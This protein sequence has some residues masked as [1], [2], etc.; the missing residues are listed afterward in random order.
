MGSQSNSTGVP[1]KDIIKTLLAVIY[2]EQW[3]PIPRKKNPLNPRSYLWRTIRLYAAR[4][5]MASWGLPYEAIAASM[6]LKDRDKEKKYFS[7][8]KD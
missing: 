7:K 4:G 8:K 5:S 3:T 6:L 1:M 2:R